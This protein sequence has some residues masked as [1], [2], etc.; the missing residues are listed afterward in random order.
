MVSIAGASSTTAPEDEGGIGLDGFLHLGGR[1][2]M[3]GVQLI[4]QTKQTE[5]R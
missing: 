1:R 4:E 2:S 5:P 3:L